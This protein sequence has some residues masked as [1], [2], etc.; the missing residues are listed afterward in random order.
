MIEKG[1]V[2]SKKGDRVLVLMESK[3]ACRSCSSKETCL[4]S[5]DKFRQ[6]EIENTLNAEKGNEVEIE[7]FSSAIMR[8]S[9]V[10]YFIPALLFTAGIVFGLWLGLNEFIS[11]GIGIAAL[12]LAFFLLYIIDKKYS[13]SGYKEPRMIEITKGALDD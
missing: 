1:T 2:I 12:V 11:F 10:L 5:D 8:K 7:M 4:S 3:D 9:F 6:I 13:V